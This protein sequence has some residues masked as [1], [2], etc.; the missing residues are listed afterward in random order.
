MKTYFICEKELLKESLKESVA[1]DSNGNTLSEHQAKY[2]R[3]SKVRD[4][5]GNLL[6]VFKRMKSDTNAFNPGRA[7]EFFSD[8]PIQDDYFGKYVGG[9]YLNIENPLIVDAQGCDW[10]YPLWRF[11]ADEDGNLIDRSEIGNYTKNNGIGIPEYIWE[12]IYDDEEEYE[13][14]S[15]GFLI[16]DY[17]L[18]YD[19][20]ILKN[21][22]EGVGDK[23]K[24]TDYIVLSKEQIERVQ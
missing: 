12:Y 3:N 7:G 17:N 9:F 5:Y 6:V 11:V 24:V 19:G 2:F 23:Q 14:D 13:F 21:V 16:N 15:L 10:S 20:V 4:K 1:V 22:Y 18:P 8:K